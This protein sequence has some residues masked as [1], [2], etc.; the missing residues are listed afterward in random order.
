MMSLMGMEFGPYLSFQSNNGDD[1][2]ALSDSLLSSSA[3]ADNCWQLVGGHLPE[4]AGASYA[5]LALYSEEC[6]EH[7][8]QFHSCVMSNDS[9]IL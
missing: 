7:P 2:K 1:A 4:A 6:L 9:T 8:L 5:F 3:F